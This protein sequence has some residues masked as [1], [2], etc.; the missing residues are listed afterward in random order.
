MPHSDL[1]CPRAA[2]RDP[3]VK[4]TQ[5][6]QPKPP[7]PSRAPV[8]IQGSD[9]PPQGWPSGA[10]LGTSVGVPDKASPKNARFLDCHQNCTSDPQ[11]G[12]SISHAEDRS[13]AAAG[14]APG[15]VPPVSHR[16]HHP[17]APPAR[18]R[19]PRL[20]AAARRVSLC[21]TPSCK[22]WAHVRSGLTTHARLTFAVS[23]QG[24]VTF[25][26][27]NQDHSRLGIFF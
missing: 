3:I 8:L 10:G 11:R 20:P 13:S 5:S 4:R 21:H 7:P 16:P 24:R 12:A 1:D 2:A 6:T 9:G 27:S 19:F 22:I 15:A 25:A 17:Q 18:R 14:S 23:N 26:V